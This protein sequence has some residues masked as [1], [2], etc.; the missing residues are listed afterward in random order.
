[1]QFFSCFNGLYYMDLLM[2]HVNTFYRKHQETA[3]FN[4]T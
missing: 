3:V 2:G 4:T 1:M